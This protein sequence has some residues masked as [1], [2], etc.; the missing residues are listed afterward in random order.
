MKGVSSIKKKVSTYWY[1]IIDG[2]KIYCGKD[3]K[4]RKLAEAAKAKN[5]TKKY[6]SRE[7]V[8]GLKVKRSELKTV[9]DLANWYMMQ[10]P[11]VQQQKSYIRKTIACSHLL[12]FFGSIP[13]NKIEGD[14]QERYREHRK[15]QG[16]MDSTVDF[17]IEVLSSMYHMACK[18]KKVPA[19]FL[20]GE[21][22]QKRK[23]NPRRIITEEEFE[24]LLKYADP[25][26]KD[27]II[28]GYESAMR[29]GEIIN[30]TKAQVKLDVK[31]ISGETMDYID[32]GIF[33]TKTGARRTV[34]ISH[35]L[36]GVLI[37]RIRELDQ[38]NFVFT[39]NKG[40]KYCAADI[41][42]RMKAA[43]E[44]AG[45]H[46]GDK[47]LNAKGEKIGIVFHCFRHTRTS[48]WVEAGFSDEIVRRATGHMNLEA[49]KR[50]VKLD[51]HVVMRLVDRKKTDNSGIK[52]MELLAR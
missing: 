32:L 29:S 9:K 17:E 44:K 40:K 48:R 24:K 12:N 22:V 28:C 35:K 36:K 26:F 27:I 23:V 20:P 25:N 52:T 4:G 14:D 2:K 5:I 33:D 11:S 34:P 15:S 39:N 38:D 7:I 10:I 37:K 45:I 1:A 46:Y 50:Y 31:H 41:S 21:F 13:L 3:E 43:C 30:L 19:D 8:A 47:V 49:Y 42:H 18:R 6:E 16:I 51:P